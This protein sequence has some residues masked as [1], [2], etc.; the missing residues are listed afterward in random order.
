MASLFFFFPR[1]MFLQYVD[2]E[3]LYLKKGFISQLVEG[4]GTL[5]TISI[6]KTGD[7]N[8]ERGNIGLV[9]RQVTRRFQHILPMT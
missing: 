2:N 3:V 5:F 1:R 4:M 9:Y 6:Q 7:K 8:T